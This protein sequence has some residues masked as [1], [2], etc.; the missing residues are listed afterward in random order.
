MTERTG[1]EMADGGDC[2][3]RRDSSLSP[4]ARSVFVL[5]GQVLTPNTSAEKGDIQRLERCSQRVKEAVKTA[6]LI[7]SSHVRS[8]SKPHFY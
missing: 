6:M 2:G 1:R 5:L 8:E 4:P 3:C 7:H